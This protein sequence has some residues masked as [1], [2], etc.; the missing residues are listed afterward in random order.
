MAADVQKF[1]GAL[2]FMRSCNPTGVTEEQIKSMAIA[3]HLGKRQNM[4]YEA[5][6]YPHDNWVH[7]LAFSVLK[8]HPKFK[9]VDT[10]DSIRNN[11][12]IESEQLNDSNNMSTI[13]S[14]TLDINS[15]QNQQQ[16]F[17]SDTQSDS[18]ILPIR[19]D[20]Q[21]DDDNEGK[22]RGSECRGGHIGRKRSKK[23]LKDQQLAEQGIKNAQRIAE[24]M[25][26]RTELIAERNALMAFSE[27]E[28][29]NEEDKKDKDE[30]M[31][32]M[33]KSHLARLRKRL[34]STT[35]I[36]SP[37][38]ITPPSTA[39][40]GDNINSGHDQMN[41]PSINNDGNNRNQNHGQITPHST[42]SDDITINLNRENHVQIE[43]DVENNSSNYEVSM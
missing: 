5:R 41:P 9:E 40:D 33:R 29:V 7:H 39:N 6:D 30:F 36:S 11:H 38:Q 20:V 14:D 2:R 1:R 34:C 25:Q 3:K 43:Q 32:L 21:R 13:E 4:S 17:L 15:E 19:G 37:S 31:R 18:E 27:S 28:C 24:S 26:Q 35:T 42:T 22:K 8:H 23:D 12:S 10:N 16:K